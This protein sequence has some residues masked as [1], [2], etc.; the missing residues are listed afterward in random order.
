MAALVGYRV[1]VAVMT[2]TWTRLSWYGRWRYFV[3]HYKVRW[4][5][6]PAHISIG[7][8][9]HWW[10]IKMVHLTLHLPFG[11]LCIGRQA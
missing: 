8:S 5:S 10:P 1:A 6:E 11:A 4:L 2:N 7:V 9:L 3:N